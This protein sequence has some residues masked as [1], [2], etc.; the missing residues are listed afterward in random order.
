MAGRKRVLPAPAGRAPLP[1]G[2]AKRDDL[3]ETNRRLLT[4]GLEASA[5]AE[6]QSSLASALRLLLESRDQ[7]EQGLQEENQ[8]LRR[9]LR[10][11]SDCGPAPAPSPPPST[12]DTLVVA[13]SGPAP[14]PAFDA[15]ILWG[16]VTAVAA[17]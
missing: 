3:R 12:T 10:E 13:A 1:R 4:A 6:A 2:P 7:M 8:L 16:E 9:K 11:M 15:S 14:A 5:Q 17:Q